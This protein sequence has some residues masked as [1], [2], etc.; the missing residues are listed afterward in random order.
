MSEQEQLALWELEQDKIRQ[1]RVDAR[2]RNL[3]KTY[4]PPL[5]SSSR[6]VAIAGLASKSAI[7]AAVNK[8]KPIR[9][10]KKGTPSSQFH[11]LIISSGRSNGKTKNQRKIRKW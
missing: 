9:A 3:E 8:D 4:F 2:M 10:V 11:A 5:G 7:R 6:G 1:Q